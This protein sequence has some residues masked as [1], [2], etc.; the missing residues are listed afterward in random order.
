[1][2]SFSYNKNERLKIQ[3]PQQI[4]TDIGLRVGDTFLDIGSNDGFFT[5]PASLMVK[6]SGIVYAVD[7]DGDAIQRLKDSI[8]EMNISNINYFIM[9]AEDFLI[10]KDFADIVFFGTVLHDFA[11]PNKVLQNAFSMLKKGGKIVDFDWRKEDTH[12]GPPIS[13]RLSENDVLNMLEN[14]GFSSIN[15]E[16]KSSNFYQIKG[17][18]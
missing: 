18:K 10:K 15:I 3:D 9:P 7:I 4:L 12:I 1:M 6:D 16:T 13:I 8:Q 2:H 5:I 11:N 17:Y 14:T